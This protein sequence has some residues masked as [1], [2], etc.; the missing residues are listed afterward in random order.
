[1]QASHATPEEAIGIA[2]D[3]RARAALGMH[4][5]TIMLTPEDPFE[6]AGRFRQAAM[7]QQFGEANAWTLPIGGVRDF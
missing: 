6:A 2:R 4:W 5:G 7:E 1:M 3:L